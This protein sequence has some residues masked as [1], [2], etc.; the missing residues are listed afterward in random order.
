MILAA[1]EGRSNQDIAQWFNTRT[2]TVC[3]WRRRFA[4]HGIQGLID[5]SRP[6]QPRDYSDETER[7]ILAVLKQAPP[8]AYARWNGRLIAE[9]LGDVTPRH[10]WRVLQNRG[11][12]LA[13]R[14]SWCVSTDPEFA[15][16]ASDIVGL[17]LA[18]PQNAMVICV[19]EKPSIQALERAQGWL[20]LPNGRA[21]TGFSHEYTRHGTTTL[22]AALDVATG[23][24]KTGHFSRRRRREFLAFMNGV[25]T[26]YPSDVTLHVVLD[27][28]STHKPKEDRWLRRHPNVR[29]HYTP[30]HASWLN[31]AEIWFSILSRG[32]LQG[33]SF[34]SPRQV[35]ESID[36][37]VT[38]YC[39]R[40]HPFE[41]TK[42]T[43]HQ[44]SLKDKYAF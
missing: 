3:K 36:T 32:A 7:R 25:V 16:K 9:R 31:Q 17:Y 42:T 10:V 2:A 12:S 22:F 24:V 27:N 4:Q 19:D 1:A 43:V 15:A 28:A 18:P 38:A 11:I 41:W 26:M 30:T 44:Q 5:E 33:T 40:A 29:F 13:R 39:Q 6:G 35:R 23:T 37:F 14:R 34:T 21:I 20:R 8:A